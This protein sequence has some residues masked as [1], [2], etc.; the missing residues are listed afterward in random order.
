[1]K[2]SKVAVSSSFE[3]DTDRWGG[4]IN[5][6]D[7]TANA[8]ECARLCDRNSNCK[9]W[10]YYINTCWLKGS[11]GTPSHSAGTISGVKN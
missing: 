5:N 6:G 1:V 3:F 7:L 4:D 11:I 9:A 10:T 8:G 2:G